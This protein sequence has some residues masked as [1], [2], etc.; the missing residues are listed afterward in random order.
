MYDETLGK[1]HFWSSMIFFNIT[2]FVM[3]F[4]GLAGMPRRI[5]DYPQQF[6][7]WNMISLDRRVLVSA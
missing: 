3:H 5:P 4:L 1:F 7:D 6:A 2:F